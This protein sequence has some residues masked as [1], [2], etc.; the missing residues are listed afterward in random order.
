VY[1][2]QKIAFEAVKKGRNLNHG[3]SETFAQNKDFAIFLFN[4]H[5]LLLFR[6]RLTTVVQLVKKCDKT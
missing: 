6:I 3:A 2:R 5:P 4:T 1:E